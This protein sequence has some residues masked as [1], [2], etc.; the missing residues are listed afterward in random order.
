MEERVRDKGT[1]KEE[2]GDRRE[3]IREG[4]RGLMVE[5]STSDKLT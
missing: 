1:V 5:R 3:K 4:G 2:K